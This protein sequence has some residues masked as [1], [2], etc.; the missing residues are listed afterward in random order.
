MAGDIDAG[1]RVWNACWDVLKAVGTEF[2]PGQERRKDVW[3]V[4]VGVL[5]GVGNIWRGMLVS[6]FVFAA[7]AHIVAD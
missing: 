3:E 2:G 4:A 5:W 7:S 1:K 6:L